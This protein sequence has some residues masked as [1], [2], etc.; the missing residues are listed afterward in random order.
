METKT[1]VILVCFLIFII[2]I[3]RYKGAQEHFE[4][5]VK[6]DIFY[7]NVIDGNTGKAT[8]TTV[9]IPLLMMPRSQT[10]L[11][12]LE[13]G[14]CTNDYNKTDPQRY[15]SNLLVYLREEEEGGAD[16]S[17]PLPEIYRLK[18]AELPS[19]A[20][21]IYDKPS[22]PDIP[23]LPYAPIILSGHREITP[24][25]VS[26]VDQNIKKMEDVERKMVPSE[27]S[28]TT[29]FTAPMNMPVV[30]KPEVKPEKMK[31]FAFSSLFKK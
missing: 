6:N 4:G 9:G 16:V 20:P 30:R 23:Y 27:S 13:H 11:M 24:D 12:K 14:L 18:Y 2:F 21:F 5:N 1:I 26:T 10:G 22:I 31:T 29:P 17:V 7:A 8:G 25:L 15:I 28:S 3:V 19:C